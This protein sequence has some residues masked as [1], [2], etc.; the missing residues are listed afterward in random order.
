MSKIKIISLNVNGFNGFNGS[1]QKPRT[2]NEQINET[3]EQIKGFLLE[4][5]ADVIFLQEY[6][7]HLSDE[8][9]RNL[10]GDYNY[11]FPKFNEC[12]H[13]KGKERTYSVTIAFN[14]KGLDF[15]ISFSPDDRLRLFKGKFGNINFL[16]IHRFD[17]DTV[18]ILKERC[19]ADIIIGDFNAHDNGPEENIDFLNKLE[20]N[21]IDCVNYSKIEGIKS[22][23]TFAKNRIDRAYIRKESK[24]TVTNYYHECKTLEFSDHKAIILELEVTES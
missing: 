18:H 14:K 1:K 16:S 11:H 21:H 15:E 7:H 5:D 9:E 22:D 4:Q 6:N 3:I 8:F 10:S 2:K 12:K 24:I 19:S 13:P 17:A 20:K 23:P